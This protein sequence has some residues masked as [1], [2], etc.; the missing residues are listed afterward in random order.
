MLCVG[1]RRGKW[2]NGEGGLRSKDRVKIY[3][4]FVYFIMINGNWSGI[5]IFRLLEIEYFGREKREVN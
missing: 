4:N 1:V 3:I 2:V 5:H